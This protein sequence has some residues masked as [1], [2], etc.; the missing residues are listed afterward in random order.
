MRVIKLCDKWAG[1]VTN[2]AWKKKLLARPKRH[3]N[4]C[5]QFSLAGELT[6]DRCFGRGLVTKLLFMGG[7]LSGGCDLSAR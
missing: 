4:L 5:N 6:D 1:S 7:S 3:Q 2:G